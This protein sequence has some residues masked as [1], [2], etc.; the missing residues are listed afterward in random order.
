MK[1]YKR[2]IRIAELIRTKISE[3]ILRKINDPRIKSVTITKVD[4]S[5]DLRHAKVYFSLIG[6][7]EEEKQ[8]IEGLQKAN[9]YIRAIIG[10]E[11]GLR[12]VPELRFEFDEFYQQ[13]VKIVDLLGKIEK[14][15]S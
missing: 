15:G 12:Y 6:S 7:A 14:E 1:S 10:Q 5:N 2:S 3:I 9:K 11:L 8:S 13:S 4:L